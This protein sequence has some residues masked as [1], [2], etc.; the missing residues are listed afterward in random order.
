M[1]YSTCDSHT[2]PHTRT[3][4][5]YAQLWLQFVTVARI[6]KCGTWGHPFS[7]FSPH[8]LRLSGFFLFLFLFMLPMFT[9]ST[10]FCWSSTNHQA[11]CLRSVC[12]WD[13]SFF[14]T[15]ASYQPRCCPRPCPR[16]RRW[17]PAV[18]FSIRLYGCIWF[19]CVWFP[20]RW[21]NVLTCG[22][23][24]FPLPFLVPSPCCLCLLLLQLVLLYTSSFS[25][26]FVVSV[27]WRILK[28][29]K[30]ALCLPFH[31]GFFSSIFHSL[32]LVSPS[33]FWV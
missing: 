10:T 24:E 30:I 4:T 12:A 18:P 29:H 22:S 9:R 16:R 2:H 27:N 15:S 31:F 1:V 17:C 20:L 23:L 5:H 11:F 3:H 19:V 21:Q 6:Y 26:A 33:P 25:R 14:Y 32:P 8:S 7:S 28:T 13:L